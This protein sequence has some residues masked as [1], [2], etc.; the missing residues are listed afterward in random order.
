MH[1]VV[2]LAIALASASYTSNGQFSG[3]EKIIHFKVYILNCQC[4]P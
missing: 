1:S 3:Y 2:I 4:S